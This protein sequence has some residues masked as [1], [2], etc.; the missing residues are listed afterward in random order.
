MFVHFGNIMHK[1]EPTSETKAIVKALT[2]FGRTQDDIAK[3]LGISDETL[4]KYYRYE[5][6]SA[7]TGAVFEVGKRLM[8]K[9][10]EGDF[11][12][13]KFYLCTQGRWTIAKEKEDDTQATVIEMLLQQ[14]AQK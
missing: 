11:N 14:L 7:K 6:D 9:I 8:D 2:A 12:A 1:H 13:I 5:M 4:A 3:Y 10:E